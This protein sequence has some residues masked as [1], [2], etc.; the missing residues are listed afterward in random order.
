MRIL[1]TTLLAGLIGLTACNKG[2]N[3]ASGSTANLTSQTDSISY[4]LGVFFSGGLKADI[5]EMDTINVELL[6]TGFNDVF[7][8]NATTK[9]T[10]EESRAILEAYF[11]KMEADKFAGEI[12]NSQAF[13][14]EYAQQE[15]V[16][17]TDSG[18]LYKIIK[19]GNGEVSPTLADQV[20]CHYAGRLTNG[21][22]FDASKDEPV[23]FGVGQVI[24]GW[25]EVLQMMVE[26][27]RFEVVIPSELAYGARGIQGVIPPYSTLI[28]EMELVNIVE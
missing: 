19:K 9:L 20:Q 15:G 13:M 26:G 18:I 22:E 23:Q 5:Q 12:E 11:K 3:G 25:T 2:N 7:S 14:D 21:I 10:E 1:T 27:D 17:S 8:D 28:F 4:A 6:K 24:P 16:Y